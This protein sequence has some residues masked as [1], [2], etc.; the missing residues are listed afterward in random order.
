MAAI[1]DR[2]S[3]R[4]NIE[5]DWSSCIRQKKP[6]H[7]IQERSWLPGYGVTARF[8]PSSLCTDTA[9]CLIILVPAQPLSPN[10]QSP[11]ARNLVPGLV[12]EDHAA[13]HVHGGCGSVSSL[14]SP[15]C[16]LLI[17][18]HTG[19]GSDQSGVVGVEHDLGARALLFLRQLSAPGFVF[20]WRA[21]YASPSSSVFALPR[22]IVCVN[23]PSATA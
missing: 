23:P 1:N 15:A 7:R 4:R 17:V 2:I 3:Q 6:Q 9:L 18:G 20:R 5:A 21:R 19:T 13:H 14:E 11:S 12:S 16:L 22:A 10:N 8:R